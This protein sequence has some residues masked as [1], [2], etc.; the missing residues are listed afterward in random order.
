MLNDLHVFD[1]V[2]LSWFDLSAAAVG[3]SPAAR[4]GAGLS[5]VGLRLYV[6][7]GFSESGSTHVKNICVRGLRSNLSIVVLGFRLLL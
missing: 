3:T 6:H 2:K 7:A 5:A 4:A 1:P